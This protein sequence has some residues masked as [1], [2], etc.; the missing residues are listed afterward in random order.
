[1]SPHDTGTSL[2]D[3]DG[4]LD[5]KDCESPQD[6]TKCD[7]S[8]CG[9]VLDHKPWGC[10]ACPTFLYN[11]QSLVIKIAYLLGSVPGALIFCSGY[12]WKTNMFVSRLTRCFTV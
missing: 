2:M 1:M 10:A 7:S 3:V 11:T 12:F 9:W 4:R 5:F 8:V 6:R